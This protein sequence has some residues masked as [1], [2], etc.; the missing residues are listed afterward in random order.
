MINKFFFIFV[1]FL[2]LSGCGYEPVYS[3]KNLKF[4][5]GSVEKDNTNLN[6]KFAKAIK[7]FN[8]NN[9]GEKINIKIQSN[10]EILIKSKDSKGNAL[11]FEIKIN[12]LIS[13]LSEDVIREKSF[14][15]KMTYNNSDDKFK[16]NR[17]KNELE[18]ILITKLVEDLINYLSINQ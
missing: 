11:V 7:S 6:N 5:I 16:L 13:N 8:N 17:Y 3:T 2:I 9:N 14:S 1:A 4:S 15:R 18:K 12:L 10:K